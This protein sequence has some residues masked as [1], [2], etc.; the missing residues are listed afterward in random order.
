[1]RFFKGT[2]AER[3]ASDKTAEAGD[4]V[5][6]S[7]TGHIAVANGTDTLGDLQRLARAAEVT[8]AQTAAA[9]DATT[10]ANA[11]RAGA[12]TDVT[13]DIAGGSGPVAA[14]LSASIGD[15]GGDLFVGAQ[16]AK[17]TSGAGTSGSPFTHADGFGG[18]TTALAAAR[19]SGKTAWVPRG[20]YQ[21]TVKLVPI[22]GDHIHWD[23]VTLKPTGF[24]AASNLIEI[25]GTLGTYKTGIKMTGSLHIDFSAMGTTVVR[26]LYWQYLAR[27]QFP[28]TLTISGGYGNGIHAKS[29]HTLR[30][31]SFVGVYDRTY[32]TLGASAVY[33][34][35]VANSSGLESVWAEGCDEAVDLA[36][37]S[38]VRGGHIMN[39]EGKEPI[40]IGSSQ[41]CYFDSATGV[42]CRTG[43]NFKVDAAFSGGLGCVGNR[44]ERIVMIDMAANVSALSA[45]TLAGDA[46]PN[47][48]NSAGSVY[49]RSTAANTRAVF[50]IAADAS[51]PITR[52]TV[53]HYDHIGPG[54]TVQA[55]WTVDCSIGDESSYGEST[56]NSPVI[57]VSDSGSEVF[58]HT[59]LMIKGKAYAP[60]RSGSGNGAVFLGKMSGGAWQGHVI[61]SGAEGVVTYK[62]KGV[63]VGGTIEECAYSGL[64][65]RVVDDANYSGYVDITWSGLM[66]NVA[67][68]NAG[69][70]SGVRPV[71]E[72]GS[73]TI[74]GIFIAPESA[75]RDTQVSHTTSVMNFG[76]AD[77]VYINATIDTGISAPLIGTTPVTAK[78]QIPGRPTSGN[79]DEMIAFMA[80]L[81]TNGPLTGPRILKTVTGI[82]GKTVATTNLYTVPTG[83][84]VILGAVVRMTGGSGVTVA[85]TLG[86]GVAAG[87]DDIFASTTLTGLTSSTK[88][89]R[90]DAGSGLLNK[91]AAGDVIKLGIDTGATATTQTLT[92]DLIGYVVV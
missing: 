60:S 89:W 10:K 23:N 4:L 73:P 82:D 14:V 59:R 53:D 17:P 11:A 20:V 33:L 69:V 66:K 70:D 46:Q 87:E 57:V 43:V 12:V 78:I 22:S 62:S 40:D 76:T 44:V 65:I 5:I 61:G 36:D 52:F 68:S 90:F 85:P 32:A 19:T 28:L 34:E 63:H 67:K 55:K 25:I 30:L 35:S 80:S 71:A 6:E 56:G 15:V 1:M 39:I 27:S 29:C 3:A 48:G 31:P 47:T 84:A 58:N 91:R 2:A 38:Y 75:F 54:E 21:P 16:L 86:I 7:D 37:C 51:N 18:V 79:T 9:T 49:S 50:A 26:A 88:F 83:G 13:A 41:Y 92:V 24:A 81:Q 64:K 74:R 45:T 8:A 72:S 77:H 42:N